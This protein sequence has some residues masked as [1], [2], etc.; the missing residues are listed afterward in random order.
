MEP[1]GT[2]KQQRIEYV[3]QMYL[4]FWKNKKLFAYDNAWFY[5]K[6]IHTMEEIM[7][8]GMKK[9]EVEFIVTDEYRDCFD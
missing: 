6:L 9:Q 7:K 8:A 3:T 1:L 2:R 5:D 4:T